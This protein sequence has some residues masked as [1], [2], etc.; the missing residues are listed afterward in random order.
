M[1]RVP[2]AGP[3]DTSGLERLRSSGVDLNRIRAVVGKTEGN[4]L[5][6]DFTRELAARAWEQA[7]S[8]R[9]LT[10]MSGG[11]EGVLSPH[12]TLLADAD[13]AAEDERGALA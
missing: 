12:V 6:N 3:S 11:T 8:E 10:I 7:L 4:G 9:V 1:I 5:V 2:T 13:S